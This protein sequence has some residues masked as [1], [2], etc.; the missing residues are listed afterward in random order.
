MEAKGYTVS[1]HTDF[2]I[3]DQDEIDKILK[4]IERIVSASY[5][6]A[7]KGETKCKM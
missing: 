7:S 1:I 4:R 5:A 2:V 6:R 3:Q